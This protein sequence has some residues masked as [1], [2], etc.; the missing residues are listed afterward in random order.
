[1]NDSFAGVELRIKRAEQLLQHL[2]V[3]TDA[4]FRGDP[5]LF[6]P[7]VGESNRRVSCVLPDSFVLPPMWS[8][9][10]AEIAYHTRSALDHLVW[11]L[12]IQKTGVLPADRIEFPIVETQ[13][14]F[15]R[16]AG[17]YLAGVGVK[18]RAI[19]KSVQPFASGGAARNPLWQLRQLSVWT[20]HSD[21][22][23]GVC[24]K[25]TLGHP[26]L[27]PRVVFQ[28]P[29]FVDDPSVITVLHAAAVMVEGLVNR[30]R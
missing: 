12:A 26:S 11:Q 23:L 27:G 13:R 2:K 25:C 18:E 22:V 1:M 5:S 17:K 15:E 4:L 29:A 10:V 20:K 30:F 21:V 16:R 3:E 6:E 7:A 9:Q 28:Q 8:V 14:G 24:A 19:I